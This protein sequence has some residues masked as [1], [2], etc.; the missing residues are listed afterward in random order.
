MEQRKDLGKKQK[1]RSKLYKVRK[2]RLK[3]DC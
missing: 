2:V 1:K 3:P